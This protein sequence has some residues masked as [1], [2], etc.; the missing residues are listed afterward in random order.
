MTKAELALLFFNAVNCIRMLAYVPQI[1]TIVRGCHGAEGVSCMSW[2]LFGLAHFAT[3]LYAW[4]TA[5][6]AWMAFVFLVNCAA[7]ALIIGLAVYKRATA[8]RLATS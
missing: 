5:G 1:V 3:A 4:T 8:T 2:A 7:C 6:D